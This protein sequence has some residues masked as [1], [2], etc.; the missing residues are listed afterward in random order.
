[1]GEGERKEE[2][3]PLR[4]RG[5]VGGEWSRWSEWFEVGLCRQDF[6]WSVVIGGSGGDCE[7]GEKKGCF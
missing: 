4:L 7:S 3:Q 2:E 5:V 1:M 6:F